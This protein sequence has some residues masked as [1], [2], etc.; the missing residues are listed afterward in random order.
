[1]IAVLALVVSIAPWTGKDLPAAATD[2]T[3]YRLTLRGAPNTAAHLHADGVARGWIAAF[4]D[5]RVCSPGKIDVTL[6]ASG[7]VTLQFDLIREEE[8]AGAASGAVIYG[9]NAPV[10]VK[11][12]ARAR[13]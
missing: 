7:R 13:P 2:G 4:C 3:K 10:R 8:T 9:G 11:P 1:M 6:P 5:G 12:V